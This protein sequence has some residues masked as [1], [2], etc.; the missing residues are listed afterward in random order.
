MDQAKIRL[1]GAVGSNGM[2]VCNFLD[3]VEI[4]LYHDKFKK[5]GIEINDKNQEDM[6]IEIIEKDDETL[7]DDLEKYLTLNE[8]ISEYKNKLN[9]YNKYKNGEDSYEEYIMQKYIG[10]NA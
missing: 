1:R 3:F 6:Y 7:L 8:R 9:F 10:I 5:L 2:L 4:L